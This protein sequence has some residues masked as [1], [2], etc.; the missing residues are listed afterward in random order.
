MAQQV[1][2]S[3]TIKDIWKPEKEGE[4]IRGFYLEKTSFPE[5]KYD[6]PA[7]LIGAKSGVC[8]AVNGDTVTQ[9]NMSKLPEGQ[10][11]FV[12]ITY[13]GKKQG[14]KYEYKDYSFDA[15]LLDDDEIEAWSD[16][17]D[18]GVEL[19]SDSEGKPEGN[20]DDQDDDLPF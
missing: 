1:N 19:V 9:R 3:N 17:V 13:N 7:Y 16:K 10:N 6:K 8:I 14:K 5:S 20:S 15:W 12:Q 4:T 18:I 2:L 11:V